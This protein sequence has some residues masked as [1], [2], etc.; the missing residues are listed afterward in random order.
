MYCLQVPPCVFQP[1]HFT[2][3]GSEGVKGEICCSYI[4][5]LKYSSCS[6]PASVILE[7]IMDPSSQE[8]TTQQGFEPIISR[9]ASQSLT[10]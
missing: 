6:V 3:W 9:H 8:D 5:T 4:Q 10:L 7:A 1:G 2:G